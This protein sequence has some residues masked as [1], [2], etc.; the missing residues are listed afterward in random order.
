MRNVVSIVDKLIRPAEYERRANETQKAS[1][2]ARA[3]VEE[4]HKVKE[5]RAQA[6]TDWLATPMGQFVRGRIEADKARS[7]EDMIAEDDGK[8]TAGRTKYL[9][10]DAVEEYLADIIREFRQSQ[11]QQMTRG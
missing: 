7:I 6:L 2:A 10:A 3:K 9:V 11:I 8:R 4:A 5:E 1:E